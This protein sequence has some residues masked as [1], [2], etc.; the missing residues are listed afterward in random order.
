MPATLTTVLFDWDGTLFD[1]AAASLRAFQKM[2][3]E[4]GIDFTRE[5]HDELYAPDW[6]GMYRMLELPPEQWEQAD[7]RWLHHYADEEPHL[8]EGAAEAIA[9]LR[10]RGLQLG[11]V[12]SGTRSRIER[13]IERLDLTGVFG[14]LVCNEDVVNR[15]PHPE[16]LEHAIRA[17]GCDAGCCCF[18]GD[19]PEDIGM[20]KAARMW[21]V[22]VPSGYV[23]IDRLAACGADVVIGTIGELPEALMRL[24]PA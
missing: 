16:G 20:G 3:R 14:A 24:P 8:I 1:S 9:A 18:V 22:A 19:T 13:E 6:Y 15:K 11:I 10:A 21:T 23:A 7:R 5:R 2:F 17:I 12:S 4:F